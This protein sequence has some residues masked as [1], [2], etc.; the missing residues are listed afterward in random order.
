MIVI[1]PVPP[2][3]VARVLRFL[4]VF[5]AGITIA[6]AGELCLELRLVW[7]ANEEKSPD[8]LH[9]PLSAEE[10]R[11]LQKVFKWKHYFEVNGQKISPR[12]GETRKIKMSDKC[13]V[14]T[15]R[16]GEARLE[17]KLVGDGKLVV[18]Q[19]ISLPQGES[20]ILAGDDKND[21]AWFV[22]IKSVKCAK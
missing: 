5:F 12:I 19:I 4:L 14:E 7:G 9:K 21:T 22:I 17:V 11:E 16:L 15:K 2:I 8:P 20:L 3:R 13:V 1:R 10:S 6:S 18:R